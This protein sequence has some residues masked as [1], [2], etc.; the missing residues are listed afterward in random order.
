[1][2]KLFSARGYAKARRLFDSD[3]KSVMHEALVRKV[4]TEE[5]LGAR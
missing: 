2:A 4:T 3:H 5:V 1:M